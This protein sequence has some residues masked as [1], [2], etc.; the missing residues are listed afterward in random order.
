MGEEQEAKTRKLEAFVW[1][2][3]AKWVEDKVEEQVQF[4][5]KAKEGTI[6]RQILFKKIDWYEKVKWHFQ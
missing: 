5:W 6:I 3:R 2:V 4:G 1:G